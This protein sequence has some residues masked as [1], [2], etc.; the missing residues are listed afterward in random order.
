MMDRRITASEAVAMRRLAVFCL[1]AALPSFPA[2]GTEDVEPRAR[3]GVGS[4]PAPDQGALAIIFALAGPSPIQQVSPGHVVIVET[5]YVLVLDDAQVVQDLSEDPPAPISVFAGSETVVGYLPAGRH[6]FTVIAPG[7]AA[8]VFDTDAEIVAGADNHLYLFGPTDA[9]Q[10]RFISFPSQPAPGTLHVSA[11]NLILTG[12]S[13][14]VVGC[15]DASHCT[16]LSPPFALGESFSADFAASQLSAEPYYALANGETL[17]LREVASAL[18]PSPPVT[19]ISRDIL[20]PGAAGATSPV[21]NLAISP[22]FMSDGG[23]VLA[24]FD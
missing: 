1:C 16:P 2:C 17:G 6:H 19:Q 15:S 18:Q 22:I 12:Q 21:A 20:V 23:S 11:I 24:S 9:L 14:E 13:V 5:R 10:G 4:T 3:I 7:A 8:P